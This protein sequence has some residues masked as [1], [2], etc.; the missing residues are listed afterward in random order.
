V[1]RAEALFAVRR[2]PVSLLIALTLAVTVS[3][4]AAPVRAVAQTPGRLIEFGHSYGRYHR[5]VDGDTLA[6][7]DTL[8]VL[9]LVSSF[10]G[11][12]APLF[13]DHPTAEFTFVKAD[14][15]LGNTFVYLPCGSEYCAG[16]DPFSGGELRIY[17]EDTPDHDFS[18]PGSFTDGTLVLQA[19]YDS[20]T[21]YW[22]RQSPPP[23]TTTDM[24]ARL[25]F[26]GGSEFARV[27][28]DLGQG[29][30]ATEI[31]PGTSDSS[32]DPLPPELEALGYLYRF[33]TTLDLTGEIPVRS[34][35]WSSLKSL[36]R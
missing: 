6:V 32:G 14:L 23:I 18:E 10:Q 20:Y 28:N 13:T 2:R 4:P 15:I 17:R 26:T 22:T 34:T 29:F 12:L 8:V 33:Y 16:G 30:I 35:T 36:Y 7:G 24:E 27:S 25:H 5:V 11:V 1:V 21:H 3:G 9:G 31:G 19:D